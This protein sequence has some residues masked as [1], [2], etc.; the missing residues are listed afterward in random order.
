MTHKLISRNWFNILLSIINNKQ[1]KY[2]KYDLI[3]GNNKYTIIVFLFDYIFNSRFKYELV[4]VLKNYKRMHY[5][6]NEI[7]FPTIPRFIPIKNQ[8]NINKNENNTPESYI[9]IMDQYDKEKDQT[10]R[11]KNIISSNKT[12]KEIEFIV[13][14]E[15]KDNIYVGK[16]K[17]MTGNDYYSRISLFNIDNNI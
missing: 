10:T 6:I 8:T 16:M 17:K 4:Y 9:K 11:R 13:E 5:E 2:Q 1:Y 7:T 15:S 3:S 14:P 12:A